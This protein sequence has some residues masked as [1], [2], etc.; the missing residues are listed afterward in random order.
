MDI[1]WFI[2]MGYQSQTGITYGHMLVDEPYRQYQRSQTEDHM[3]L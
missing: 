3:L 1:M 2:H